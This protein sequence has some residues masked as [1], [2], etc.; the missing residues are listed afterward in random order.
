MSVWGPNGRHEIVNDTL[1]SLHTSAKT[2]R[3]KIPF[4]FSSKE[5]IF[6]A[7][8]Y[9]QLITPSVSY[10]FGEYIQNLERD[11]VFVTKII[12]ISN[13]TSSD[14][15]F[16]L[17]FFLSKR[18]LQ[19]TKKRTKSI[20]YRAVWCLYY[21]GGIL[22]MQLCRN[23]THIQLNVLSQSNWWATDSFRL[24]QETNYLYPKWIR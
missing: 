12:R 3:D 10:W 22:W 1:P 18:F 9:F 13:S 20:R 19:N 7:V 8:H 2:Y 23:L 11:P 21:F 24:C 15:F 17:F 5:G 4:L 16:F 14:F 6:I